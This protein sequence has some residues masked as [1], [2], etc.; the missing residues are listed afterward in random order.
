MR[1]TQFIDC[2]GDSI[3]APLS[4]AE[5]RTGR[6]GRAEF[7]VYIE[8]IMADQKTMGNSLLIQ[9]RRTDSPQPFRPPK[10]AYKFTRP[11]DLPNRMRGVDG[12]NFWWIELGGLQDT[13]GDAEEIRDELLR[14]AYGVWD[15]IKNHAPARA[16][17]ANWAVEWIGALPGKRENR[18]YIGDHVLSQNDIRAGGAFADI[19]R[20]VRIKIGLET[21]SIRFVPESTW[22][23][24]LVHVFEFEPV[25]H[26]EVKIPE[27]PDGPDFSTVRMNV[28]ACD[29]APPDLEK[30]AQN[31]IP[32]LRRPSA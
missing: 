21:S 16:E 8:P 18:R 11:E 29:L 24:D 26:F 12:Q 19:Q 1:A 14:T 22:G 23:S 3:L 10:W 15:Y 27:I 7:D 28:P 9:L 2:S 20:L 25:E 5:Y 32:K 17:A 30:R 6:E 13:L 4:G 31:C